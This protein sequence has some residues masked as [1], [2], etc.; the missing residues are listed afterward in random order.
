[1][2]AIADN[3]GRKKMCVVYSLFYAISCLVKMSTSYYVLMV[4]AITADHM[5][6]LS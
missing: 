2:G 1:V 4:S 5:I 3:L 6:A